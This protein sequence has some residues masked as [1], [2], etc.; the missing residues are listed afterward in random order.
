MRHT[1]S[2]S[3]RG[4]ESERNVLSTCYGS[5]WLHSVEVKPHLDAGFTFGFS[6]WE[7]SGRPWEASWNLLEASSRGFWTASGLDTGFKFGLSLWK[8]S[9]SLGEASWNLLEASSRA[10]GQPLALTQALSLA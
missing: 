4:R 2:N 9:G 5:F 10:S 1:R 6:L 7:A 8:A 3:P